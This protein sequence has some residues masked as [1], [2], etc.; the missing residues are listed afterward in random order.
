MHAEAPDGQNLTACPLR[1]CLPRPASC[2]TPG[3][4]VEFGMS[5]NGHEC[6]HN[7]SAHVCC[8]NHMCMCEHMYSIQTAE[9]AEDLEAPRALTRGKVKGRD[10]CDCRAAGAAVEEESKSQTLKNNVTH[11]GPGGDAT[12]RTIAS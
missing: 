10:T 2:H 4:H 7:T 6:N 8:P 12:A 11:I 5:C 1:R 3:A 9:K